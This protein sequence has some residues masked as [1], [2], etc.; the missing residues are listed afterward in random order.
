MNIGQPSF[1][2]FSACSFVLMVRF[3]TIQ[4][5]GE[6]E[7]QVLASQAAKKYIKSNILEAH[8]GTIYD[9]RVKS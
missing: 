9:G 2:G 7:G 5:T 8:R 3:V 1:S 6:V 4:V